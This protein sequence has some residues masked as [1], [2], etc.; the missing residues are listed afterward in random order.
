MKAGQSVDVKYALP[1]GSRMDVKIKQC[2]RL[3]IVEVF[4]CQLV[5]EQSLRVDGHNGNQRFTLGATGF[6]HFTERVTLPDPNASYR[7]I[8]KRS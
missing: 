5:S 7:V 8:W 1:A 6:Y 4:T 2:R 3:W